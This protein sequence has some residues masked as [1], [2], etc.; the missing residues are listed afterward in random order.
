MS[1]R[2]TVLSVN[3]IYRPLDWG[4]MLFIQPAPADPK[5][6]ISLPQ[7]EDNMNETETFY[8]H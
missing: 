7:K 1:D 3:D 4:Y 2:G 5:I 6:M 8:T